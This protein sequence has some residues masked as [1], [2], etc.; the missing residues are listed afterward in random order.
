[1]NSSKNSK[2]LYAE[3]LKYL[4]EDCGVTTDEDK[5]LVFEK[6]K[7]SADDGYVPA[8]NLLGIFHC[9]G[10]GTEISRPIAGDLFFSCTGHGDSKDLAIY[11]I[12]VANIAE[13]GIEAYWSEGSWEMESYF[14]K[15]ANMVQNYKL[16]KLMSMIGNHLAGELYATNSN[17]GDLMWL[18][19]MQKSYCFLDTNGTIKWINAKGCFKKSDNETFNRL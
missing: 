11:N 9:I 2:E 6:C 4:K 5:K 12:G 3:V 7:S 17:V 10:Y 18:L 8:K 19:S 15:W 16:A 13:K 1:M 14:K